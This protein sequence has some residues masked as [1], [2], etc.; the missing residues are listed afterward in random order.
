ML[1]KRS[2]SQAFTVDNF[3]AAAGGGFQTAAIQDLEMTAAVGNKIAFLQ[4]AGRLIYTFASHRQH[5]GQEFLRQLKL[6]AAHPV[7]C[8]QQPACK[9]RFHRMKLVT[10]SRLRDLSQK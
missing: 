10:D 4:F 5:V 2:G 3:V 6:I 8:H 9:P 1:S 7:V